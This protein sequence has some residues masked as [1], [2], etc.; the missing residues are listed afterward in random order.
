MNVARGAGID[1]TFAAG[2]SFEGGVCTRLEVTV[3]DVQGVDCAHPVCELQH[4]GLG[5]LH[6]KFAP[7]YLHGTSEAEAGPALFSDFSEK[8]PEIVKTNGHNEAKGRATSSGGT[9]LLVENLVQRISF[10]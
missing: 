3:R 8:V 2:Y 6:A 9:N 7:Q 5:P 1:S 4:Q 10:D